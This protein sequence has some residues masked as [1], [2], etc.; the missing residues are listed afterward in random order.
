MD[1][2]IIPAA[3]LVPKFQG[4]RRRNNYVVLQINIK[5]IESFMHTVGYQGVVDK[6]NVIQYPRFTKLII[7]DLIK[8]FLSISPRIEEDYHSIKDDILST[9]RAHRTP[10]LTTASPRGKKRKQG[11]GKTSSPQ[12]SLKITIKQTQVVKGEK[13]VESY[14]DKFVA[15]MIHDD[16]DG[17]GDRIEPGSHKEHPE[18]VNDDDDNKEE[19]KDDKEGDVMGSLETRTEKMQTPISIIPRSPR[20]NLSSEKNIAEELTN[21]VSL[22]TPSLPLHLNICT[23][24]NAFPKVHEKVDQV[25]LEI[26]PQLAERATNDLIERNM[27]RVMA[28]TTIQERD[29]F[30]AEMK[31]NPQDQANDPTLW[32]VVKRK[33]EKSSTSNT[34]CMDDE[35]HSQRH[36]DHQEDDAPLEGE[37]RVKRHKTSKSLKSAR[38][39]IVIDEDGA[40]LKDETPKLITEFKHVDK[41]VLTIFDHAR[42]EATLNDML[43]NQFRNVEKYACHLE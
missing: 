31:S 39:E 36:D 12:K 1:Q 23:S 16:V 17:F 4:I 6:K 35:I 41:R 7:A 38:E 29:T 24:K 21:I 26:V 20:I 28:D 15:S 25:L 8:K 30:Q 10:T 19:K 3:Q 33:F 32:D 13:D 34:S 40:I 11:A 43:S 14:A 27:K 2:Q 22:S 18:V 37:K 42:M 5:I 9:P